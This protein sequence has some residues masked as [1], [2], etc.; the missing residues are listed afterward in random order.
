M[1][2]CFHTE[3]R[4]GSPVVMA[5]LFLLPF[6]AFRRKCIMNDYFN[7]MGHRGTVRSYTSKNSLCGAWFRLVFWNSFS[8]RCCE[9]WL[10]ISLL[11]KNNFSHLSL[12]W[13]LF[14]RKHFLNSMWLNLVQQM[15]CWMFSLSI[16]R[17]ESCVMNL[18][19]LICGWYWRAYASN[20]WWWTLFY[21]IFLRVLFT[22]Q[23]NTFPDLGHGI[24]TTII[25]TS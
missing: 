24:A 2:N 5:I 1:E 19:L 15:Q 8:Q 23:P 22:E 18:T 9:C 14:S 20:L 3:F 17:T 4:F 11:A 6:C 12:L 16:M 13:M 21:G 25:N 7:N 10:F